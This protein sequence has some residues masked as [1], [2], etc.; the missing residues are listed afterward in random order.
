MGRI[1]YNLTELIAEA[2]NKD[3][4]TSLAVFKPT[5]ILDFS[6]EEVEREW[7]KNKI[8]KLEAERLQ[9]NLFR[10]PENPFE[11]VKKLPYKFSYVFEDNL[12]KKSKLMI[13][14]WEIG[15]LYWNCLAR[16]EGNEIAAVADVK[17]KYFD[18]F[19]KTKDLHL[20]LGTSQI[21]HYV[22][23]NP[24]MIIGTFHPKIEIQSKLF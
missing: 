14:D 11:V 15:Q 12:G 1:Y 6:V 2:Q 22:S 4:C 24:F 20:Y 7:D 10:Q 8:A 17:R 3:I 13:E 23:H 5:Q 9:F 16:H 21:H 18:D 19:A